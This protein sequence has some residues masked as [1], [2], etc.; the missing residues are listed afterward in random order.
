M[1]VGNLYG[2][3]EGHFILFL[4]WEVHFSRD[5]GNICELRH[6]YDTLNSGG[7]G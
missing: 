2:K 3:L 5:E 1:E 7:D 4:K 6:F